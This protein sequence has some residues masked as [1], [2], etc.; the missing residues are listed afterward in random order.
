MIGVVSADDVNQAK[1]D[2]T[3]CEHYD[4]PRDVVAFRFRCCDDWYPCRACHD[5][6]VGHDAQTWGPGEVDVRAVLCGACESTL[7]I[8]SYLACGHT[9]PVCGTAFNPG[10]EDHWDAYFALDA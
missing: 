5:E 3:R 7:T 10:C 4:G 2:E 6:T 9:C 8:D 1:D